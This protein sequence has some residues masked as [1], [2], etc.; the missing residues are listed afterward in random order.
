VTS[1]STV[2]LFYDAF[3]AKAG[4]KMASLYADSVEFSDPVFPC[5][6]GEDAKAMWRMLC[7]RAKDLQVDYKIISSNEN[8]VTVRWDAHYTFDATKRKVH[9][10]VLAELT[11]KD[12][13]IIRHKDL[14]NFWHWSSQALGPAGLLLG[15]S[16]F[17]QK[18]I[19]TKALASLHAFAGPK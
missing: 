17:L 3:K 8:T 18:K 6:M 7:L 4:D 11:V 15:W 14:F 10:K 5:L 19:Q 2:T 12:G 9:N 1:T 16:S 13:K